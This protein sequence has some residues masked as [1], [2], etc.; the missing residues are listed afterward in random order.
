VI[1]AVHCVLHAKK[2]PD[3]AGSGGLC[4]CFDVNWS[5]QA[6]R[7]A[8]LHRWQTTRTAQFHRW[9]AARTAQ[10]HRWQ[11][12]R[13]A[14][15]HRGT[16]GSSANLDRVNAFQCT[17]PGLAALRRSKSLEEFDLKSKRK[18]TH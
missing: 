1:G 3:P 15:F 11:A 12:T 7:T 8:Q 6:T 13:A 16:G 2:E 18:N 14:Q 5:G 10:F 17:S 4:Y 9:Q